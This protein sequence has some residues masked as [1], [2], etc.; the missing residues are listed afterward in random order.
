MTKYV[1]LDN[2][3]LS[4]LNSKPT[5][6]SVLFTG[7]VQVECEAIAASE[8]KHKFDSFRILDRRLQALRKLGVI[9]NVIGKGWVQS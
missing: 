5:L 7:P 6:F 1:K 9:K 4:R 2:A 3:I 8:G